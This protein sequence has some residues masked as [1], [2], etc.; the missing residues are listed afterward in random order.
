MPIY[1]LV[2]IGVFL[3]VGFCF[4]LKIYLKGAPFYN[5]SASEKLT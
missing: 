1:F 5:A 4:A 3:S 2:S